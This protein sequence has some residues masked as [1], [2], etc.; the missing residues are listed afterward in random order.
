VYD[1]LK[2]CLFSGFESEAAARGN[3]FPGVDDLMQPSKIIVIGIGNP[4][5]S[6]DA[7]GLIAAGV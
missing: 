6:D 7:T 3:I 4:Y 5:R 1:Q 2:S